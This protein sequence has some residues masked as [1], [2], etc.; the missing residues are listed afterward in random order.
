MAKLGFDHLR[1]PVDEEQLF[2]EAGQPLADGF[3]LLDAALDWCAENR[4]RAIVDLHILRSH[5]FNE[6]EQPLWTDADGAGALPRPVAPA[7]GAAVEAA[8]RTRSPTS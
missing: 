7:L 1:L 6:G 5:H 8:R 2:D 3:A 4:L